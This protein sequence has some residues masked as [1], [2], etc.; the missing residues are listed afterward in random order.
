MFIW[1]LFFVVVLQ[2]G[3]FLQLCKKMIKEANKMF[4]E[5]SLEMASSLL[6]Q[7]L[8]FPNVWLD[9]LTQVSLHFSIN[10]LITMFL[11]WEHHCCLLFQ[12]LSPV[13]LLQLNGVQPTRLLCPWNFPGKNTGVGCHILLQGIFPTQGSN[14]CFLP[15][16]FFATEPPGKPRNIITSGKTHAISQTPSPMLFSCLCDLDQQGL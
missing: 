10:L 11:S 12:S 6:K 4:S 13:N 2:M 5:A 14:L 1:H 3:L 9:C 7:Y 15:S 16:G 8:P